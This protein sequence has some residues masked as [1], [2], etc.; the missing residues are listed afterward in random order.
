[1]KAGS[2]LLKQRW[3]LTKDADRSK[4]LLVSRDDLLRGYGRMIDGIG[5]EKWSQVFTRIEKDKTTVSTAGKD[6]QPFAG[7]KRGDTKLRVAAGPGDDTLHFI[8]RRKNDGK[9]RVH[10][11]P[12]DY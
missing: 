4:D 11:E 8:L 6:D 2:E 5:K 12:T 3:G 1:M 9:L 10:L 7:V